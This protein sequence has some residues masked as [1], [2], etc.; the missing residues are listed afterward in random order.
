MS[1]DVLAELGVKSDS[2]AA[3]IGFQKMRGSGVIVKQPSWYIC[4]S[5]KWL[6]SHRGS[7]LQERG[8]RETDCLGAGYK[9]VLRSTKADVEA[10]L[11]LTDV[12]EGALKWVLRCAPWDPARL[13]PSERAVRPTPP[14][15]T[16]DSHW[17]GLLMRSFGKHTVATSIM[18]S[19]L[20]DAVLAV[21]DAEN[22]ICFQAQK[23]IRDT[24]GKLLMFD[25]F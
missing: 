25:C 3:L 9:D 13:P 14:S 18:M 2:A 19:G 22:E 16:V 1:I 7:V 17:K 12:D 11:E 23:C 5:V 24:E 15:K 21:H 20:T 6:L 8:L 10:C 4:L